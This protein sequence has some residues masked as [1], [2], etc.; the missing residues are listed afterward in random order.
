MD[1]TIFDF[2]FHSVSDHDLKKATLFNKSRLGESGCWIWI[3]NKRHGYGLYWH[4]G[5]TQS[6]HRVSYE[7]FVGPIPKGLHLLHSCDNPSCINPSHLR[8]GTVKEN[9][10]DR[11]AR[12]RRDV[13]GEQ[14]GTAKLTT[15]QV[16]EIKASELSNKELSRI[17]G[18][19]PD[20]IWLIRSGR[21]WKHL[22]AAS[23]GVAHAG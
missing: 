2:G 20:N 8:P 13:R 16:L 9:M 10:A 23:E 12:G 21:S 18:V 22:N 11:E 4:E 6:A 14:V 3:G 17:Y 1:T 15:A 7:V 19:R 5:K